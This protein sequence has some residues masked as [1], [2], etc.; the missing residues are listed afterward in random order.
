M[1]SALLQVAELLVQEH[2]PSHVTVRV[3][4]RHDGDEHEVV[5]T[6]DAELPPFQGVLVVSS[7]LLL[8]ARHS[9]DLLIDWLDNRLRCLA[10]EMGFWP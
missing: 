7:K 8:M 2:F 10:E 5:V 3:F 9:P 4:E 6:D 1:K